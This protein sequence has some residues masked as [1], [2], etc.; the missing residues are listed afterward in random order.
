MRNTKRRHRRH[1][2]ASSTGAESDLRRWRWA[3]QYGRAVLNRRTLVV[4]FWLSA[5]VAAVWGMRTLDRS[6]HADPA[7]SEP[8]QIVFVDDGPEVMHDK[9]Q[10]HLQGLSDGPW[11][12]P[13][14]CARIVERLVQSPWVAAV[15]SVDKR[16]DGVVEIDCAYRQPLAVLQMGDKFRLIAED[17][18]VLPGEYGTHGGLPIIQGVTTTLPAPGMALMG[19]DA[20]AG[21]AMVR[22]LRD[23]AFLDQIV[24]IRVEGSAGAGAS[25]GRNIE[26][27][28]DQNGGRIIWGSAP[29][30]EVE[31]NTTDQKLAILRS[32][33]ERS[34]RVDSDY[35]VIDISV[36]P[37]RFIVPRGA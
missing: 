21:I 9:M 17:G 20:L 35:H 14:L 2:R 30:H 33:F 34:G 11:I 27:T 36:F 29:G 31:E 8:P 25:G 28:T 19:D 22:L 32:N 6:V 26:L 15:R 3:L 12:E 24:A 37:D 1:K 4:T 13:T 16:A 5:A 7:F 10:D 23:E 18:V